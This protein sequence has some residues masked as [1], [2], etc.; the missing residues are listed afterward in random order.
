MLK[1]NKEYKYIQIYFISFFKMII[2]DKS[3][4]NKYKF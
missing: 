2:N 3:I 4:N 1:I